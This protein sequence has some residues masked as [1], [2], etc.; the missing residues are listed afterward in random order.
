[1]PRTSSHRSDDSRSLARV[2]VAGLLAW[3][4]PGAGH[5]YLGHRARS[6]IY[7][8]TI[9]VTFWGGIAIA[10]GH[11]TVNPRQRF[12]LWY[13]G[14]LCTGSHA[15]IVVGLNHH[16]GID[17][18]TMVNPSFMSVDVGVI[19]TSVAGLL[20]LLAILDALARADAPPV[21]TVSVTGALTKGET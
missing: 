6:L 21:P 10:G 7:F 5:F 16:S 14:Q 12:I 20:N 1:V 19:Y 15:L 4:L 17:P 11:D 8:V 18:Q 3:L 9:S 13:L 2:C